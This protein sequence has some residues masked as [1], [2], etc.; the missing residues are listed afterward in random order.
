MSQYTAHLDINGD[1]DVSVTVYYTA[2]RFVAGR[3]DGRGGPKLEPDE[4]AHIEIE[5][6]MLPDGQSYEPDASLVEQL[7]EE[8]AEWLHGHTEREDDE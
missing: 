4:P 3:T 2:H 6:V 5:S 8:I 7:E 1:E